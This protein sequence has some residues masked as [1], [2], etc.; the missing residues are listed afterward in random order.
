MVG[1]EDRNFGDAVTDGGAA[2]EPP[3]LPRAPSPEPIPCTSQGI[4]PVDPEHAPSD[5]PEDTPT[6]A[7]P[8]NIVSYYF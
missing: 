6:E 4:A 5:V 1:G 3:E 2:L 8:E 7:E